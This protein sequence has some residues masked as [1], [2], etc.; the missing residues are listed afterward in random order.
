MMDNNIND[1]LIGKG[2]LFPIVITKNPKNPNLSGW[3]PVS[4]D[5]DLIKHNLRSLFEHQIY[6][7]FR[8]EYYGS[9]LWETLEEPSIPLLLYITN[10]FIRESIEEWEPRIKFKDV[11]GYLKGDKIFLNILYTIDQSSDPQSLEI[12]FDNINN[13]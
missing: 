5:P 6:Q 8:Q 12:Y 10:Q 13:H 1:T 2:V 3:Y 9:R 7:R 11:E 4:G